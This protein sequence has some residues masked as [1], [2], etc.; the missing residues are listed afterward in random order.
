MEQVISFFKEMGFYNEEYF[1]LINKKTLVINK[2]Y[3]E[4]KEFVGFYPENFKLILPKIKSNRDILIWI[5]EYSHALFPNDNDELFPNIMESIYINNYVSKKEKEELKNKV[6][7]EIS[8][9][10]SNKHTLAKKMKLKNIS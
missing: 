1:K 10:N 3:E 8:H 5:H 6:L 9:S 7:D 2:D 4:I